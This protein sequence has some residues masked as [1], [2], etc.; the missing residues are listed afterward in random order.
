M[1]VN[2]DLR[3]P[4]YGD[5][6]DQTVC[7]SMCRNHAMYDIVTYNA[8]NDTIQFDAFGKHLEFETDH[9]TLNV[10]LNRLCLVNTQITLEIRGKLFKDN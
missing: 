9:K 10:K 6:A 5:K 2:N 8:D 1:V 7:Q 4:I 3:F